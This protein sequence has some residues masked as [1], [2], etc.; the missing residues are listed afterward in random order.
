[1]A[2]FFHNTIAIR[3]R[4]RSNFFRVFSAFLEH[5]LLPKNMFTNKLNPKTVV[6]IVLAFLPGYVFYCFLFLFTVNIPYWDDYD[7]IL[8]FSNDFQK[9]NIGEKIKLIFSQHNEHRIVFSRIVILIS[10]Y[11]T[12]KINFKL[13]TLIGNMSLIGLAV[14]FLKSVVFLHKKFLYFIPIIFLLF[15]PQYWGD[16]YFATPSLANFYALFF[17]F[18]A[19]YLLFKQTQRCFLYSLLLALLATFTNANGMLVFLAALPALFY[20]KKYKEI[21]IWICVGTV[22]ILVYSHGYIKPA[23]HPDIFNSVFVHPCYTIIYFFTFLGLCFSDISIN[24]GK[25]IYFLPPII[26]VIFSLYFIYLIKI[27][28]YKR[29]LVIFSFLLFLFLTSF[30][31]ALCRSGFY[32]FASRYKIIS[33]LMFALFY[34]SLI[35]ISTGNI[36]RNIY[37]ISLSFAILFN[38][39]SYSVNFRNIILQK[40]YLIEGVAL[41]KDGKSGL[42]Y[43]DANRANFI[44]ST[45]IANKQYS[46]PFP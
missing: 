5:A 31:T 19:L 23:Y 25:A 8:N 30:V 1:M 37:L 20:Q 15:Q 27:K 32:S 33:I 35:V 17:A 39:I 4:R 28:F 14:L 40:K 7:S 41:W 36:R 11:L 6:L 43:P 13:L 42:S 18:A 9:S 12:G 44:I 46:L 26:G 29:N 2:V 38:V 34:L 16:I 3:R 10:Y 24:F 21:I 45:A 22:C